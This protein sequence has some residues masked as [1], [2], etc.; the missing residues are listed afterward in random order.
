MARLF[1]LFVFVFVPQKNSTTTRGGPVLAEST[2][3]LSEP[4]T[5]SLAFL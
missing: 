2:V 3:V 1:V 5:T 4:P